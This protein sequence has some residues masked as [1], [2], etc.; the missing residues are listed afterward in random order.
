MIQAWYRR[1]K[2]NASLGNCEDAVRDLSVAVNLE[3]TMVEK[4]RI[5]SEL[6]LYMDRKEERDGLLHSASKNN[7]NSAGMINTC[8]ICLV[9]L[10]LLAAICSHIGY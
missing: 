8:S 6:K 2:A 10:C 3:L 9:L 5:E 1:G 4:R 7:I